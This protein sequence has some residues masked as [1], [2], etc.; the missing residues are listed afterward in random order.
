MG[1]LLLASMLHKL[2]MGWGGKREPGCRPE[3]AK[4]WQSQE[5]PGGGE[6]ALKGL[7]QG[8]QG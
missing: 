2:H 5:A 1:T 7:L 8:S 6:G 4:R 3:A